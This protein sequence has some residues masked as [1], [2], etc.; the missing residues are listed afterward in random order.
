M[1]SFKGDEG[2]EYSIPPGAEKEHGNDSH[3]TETCCLM[4]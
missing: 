1:Y 2:N 4:P 3:L